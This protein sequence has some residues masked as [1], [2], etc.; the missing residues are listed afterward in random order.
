MSSLRTRIQDQLQFYSKFLGSNDV[1]LKTTNL[2]VR[3]EEDRSSL[4][5]FLQKIG[6]KDNLCIN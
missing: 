3:I 4:E 6:L 1:V 5:L 2:L